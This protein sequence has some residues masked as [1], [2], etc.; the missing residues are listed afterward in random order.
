MF[1]D[2]GDPFDLIERG[3]AFDSA[4][5]HWRSADCYSRASTCLRDRADILSTQIKNGDHDQSVVSEKRKVVSLFR[6]QSLEYLYKARQCLLKAMQFENEQDHSRMLDVARLGSGSLD[7]LACMISSQ[8]IEERNLTFRR[9]FSRCTNMM[10]VGVQTNADND[11]DIDQI[12]ISSTTN[13]IDAHQQLLESRLAKLDSS[14]LPNIPP[15]VVFGSHNGTK[16]RME[17]I[18]RGLGR[19]GVSLPDSSKRDILPD[20][21]STE[22]QMK[23]II[24]QAKDEVRIER[25]MHL[26]TGY[27]SNI[28]DASLSS[29]VDD[30]VINEN[31]SMFDGFEDEEYDID[32]LLSKTES[33]LTKMGINTIGESEKFHSELVQIIRIQALLLETRLCLETARSKSNYTAKT[34][35]NEGDDD[36]CCVRNNDQSTVA[37][38][39]KA[40][41]LAVCVQDCINELLNSWK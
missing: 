3:N 39:K 5:D 25:G 40:R 12:N 29:S 4:Y 17:E 11:V 1:N 6:A 15:P 19:L 37:M 22:D 27:C 21:L 31:D 23:L 34:H 32:T 7:P 20:T 13:Q 28:L 26:E 36:E 38:K 35:E 8:D 18:H 33:L 2:E 10:E 16:N 14:L 30:N 41:S 9:L 24:N